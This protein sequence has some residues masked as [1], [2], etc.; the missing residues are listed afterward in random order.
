MIMSPSKTAELIEVSFGVW[1]RV[2]PRN[3]VCMLLF[4]IYIV[5]FLVLSEI[6]ICMYVDGDEYD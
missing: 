2:G 4:A 6:H 5:G 1:T 3:R